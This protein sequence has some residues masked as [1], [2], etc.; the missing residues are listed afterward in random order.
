M[1]V[2]Y[3]SFLSR[4]P[5]FLLKMNEISSLTHRLDDIIQLRLTSASQFVSQPRRFTAWELQ[6][7]DVFKNTSGIYLEKHYVTQ[8]RCIVFGK[9]T[10]LYHVSPQ[11]PNTT[12]PRYKLLCNFY[13]VR[14]SLSEDLLLRHKLNWSP[15]CCIKTALKV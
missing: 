1:S 2:T 11:T 3:V 14:S 15:I 10:A 9:R 8:R 13:V 12:P 5:P 4:C 7:T 6:K